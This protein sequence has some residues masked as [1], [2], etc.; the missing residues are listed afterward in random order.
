MPQLVLTTLKFLFL[1]LLYL[2]LARAIRVIYLDLV[3]PRVPRP[4]KPATRA[5]APKRK[6][7]APKT[8]VVKESEGEPR[9]FPV[10]GE[11]LTIGRAETCE[12][13][14][15]DTY[16]SQF[17]ARI[18]SQDGAWFVEDL[19]STNGTYLNR[20]KVTHPSPLAAGDEIRI[21]KTSIEAR[22]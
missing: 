7:V 15:S 10:A 22:R 16:A 18:Y 8:I 21:G 12:I 9:T 14:L 13:V 6:R 5:D 11:P 17:H 19:G 2:F 4:Q 3:G 1:A 20:L